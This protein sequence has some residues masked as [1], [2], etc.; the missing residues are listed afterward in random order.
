MPGEGEILGS[1]VGGG[2]VGWGVW[3]CTELWE[4]G[5]RGWILGLLIWWGGGGSG[6]PEIGLGGKGWGWGKC[7]SSLRK[8]G[9]ELRWGMWSLVGLR[10]KRTCIIT[11]R[12]AS[13]DQAGEELG[14][15]IEKALFSLRGPAWE[16]VYGPFFPHQVTASGHIESCSSGHIRPGRRTPSPFPPPQL[17]QG[18]R[19]SVYWHNIFQYSLCWLPSWQLYIGIYSLF[20]KS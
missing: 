15:Q 17:S 13:G 7:W 4:G 8:G 10:Y 12:C 6:L 9:W 5:G 2:G 20:S 16:Q 18:P 11:F 1:D 19:L 3:G 14:H